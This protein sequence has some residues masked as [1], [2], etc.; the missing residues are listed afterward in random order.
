MEK[1]GERLAKWVTSTNSA[2]T[3]EAKEYRGW[4][5]REREMK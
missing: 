2:P 4:K 3:K 5:E 1:W